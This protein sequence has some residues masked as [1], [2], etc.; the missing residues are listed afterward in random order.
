[1]ST[2]RKLNQSLVDAE[3]K[4]EDNRTAL[5]KH[6]DYFGGERIGENISYESMVGRNKSIGDSNFTAK[7]TAA[8]V[9]FG[10]GTIIGHCPFKQFK[11]VEAVGKLNHS[12]HTGI[13]HLDGTIN[14]TVWNELCQYATLDKTG[15]KIF[16]KT[17]F[18]E[19]L[20][21]RRKEENSWDLFGLLASNG[22]WGSYWEKFSTKDESD[23]LYVTLK[24]LRDFFEDSS[25]PG[26]DVEQRVKNRN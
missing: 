9:S 21:A 26:F 6:I 18:D 4:S 1:M 16:T 7:S 22:E 25:K 2:T 12:H 10:A 20:A 5:E 13:Y 19:F 24:Q 15:T 3:N 17:R 8:R 14:E 11:P 23:V